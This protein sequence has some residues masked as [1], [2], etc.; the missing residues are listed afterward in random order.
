M[1][2]YFNVPFMVFAILALNLTVFA[3]ALQMNLLS[4]ESDTAK[5]VAWS[6]S[7]GLWH[8]AYRFRHPRH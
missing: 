2:G 8:M 6:V 3:V 4:I 5:V 7:V 1:F